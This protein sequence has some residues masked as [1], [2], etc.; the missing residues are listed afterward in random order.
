MAVC[1][2]QNLQAAFKLGGEMRF[3]EVVLAELGFRFRAFSRDAR[4]L[5]TEFCRADRIGVERF[6]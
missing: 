2:S 1:V 4:L 3:L 5:Y 6:E